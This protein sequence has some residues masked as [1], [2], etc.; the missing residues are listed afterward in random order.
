MNIKLAILSMAYL[1][2]WVGNWISFEPL[3]KSF[4]VLLPETPSYSIKSMDTEIG[5]VEVEYYF[6]T[7]DKG[8]DEIIFSINKTSYPSDF[9]LA[10]MDSSYYYILETT[11]EGLLEQLKGRCLYQGPANQA[12]VVGDRFSIVYQSAGDTMVVNTWM[13]PKESVLF[14][15][16]TFAPISKKLAPEIN[17]F[18][19]SFQI[20]NY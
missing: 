7:L 14:T 16:Q 20:K 18:F 12:D 4:H 3:D 1:L 10:K 19:D 9:S 11:R 13:L 2:T 6:A 15:L 17:K 8:K 5:N